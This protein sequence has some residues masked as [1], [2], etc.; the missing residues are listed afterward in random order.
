MNLKSFVVVLVT[1]V[2]PMCAQAQQGDKKVTKADAENVYK[3]ISGDKTKTQ[4][5]CDIAQIGDQ[6]DQAYETD[7][8]AEVDALS[9]KV[10]E[11][12]KELGSEYVTLMDEL[13]EIDPDSEEGLEISTT[14]RAL[15]M[16][17][18]K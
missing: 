14:L 1:A 9:K 13:V 12:E 11:L 6:I 3:M 2:V 4:I 18:A 10:G 7:D 16:L 5:Y 8:T 15:E 17:C